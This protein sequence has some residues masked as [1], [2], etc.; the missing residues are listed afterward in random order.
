MGIGTD[1]PVMHQALIF[2]GSTLGEE[3]VFPRTGAIVIITGRYHAG[4]SIELAVGPLAAL[5]LISIK[6]AWREMKSLHLAR[7]SA[8]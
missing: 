3:T 2:I 7:P 5:Q 6:F 8:G 1:Q 4:A